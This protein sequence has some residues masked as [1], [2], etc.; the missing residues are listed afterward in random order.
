[1][2]REIYAWTPLQ[3]SDGNYFLVDVPLKM[4]AYCFLLRFQFFMYVLQVFISYWEWLFFEDGTLFRLFST[5]FAC[6]GMNSLFLFVRG[7][8]PKWNSV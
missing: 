6:F 2:R 5:E 4:A 1:M 7:G 8:M 3:I